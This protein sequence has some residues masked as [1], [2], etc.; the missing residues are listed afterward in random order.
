MKFI[1]LIIITIIM[2][3]IINKIETIEQRQSIECTGIQFKLTEAVFN[4]DCSGLD[5]NFS[6]FKY[7]TDVSNFF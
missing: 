3:L 6:D 4:F 2:G 7:F 5:L 1:K